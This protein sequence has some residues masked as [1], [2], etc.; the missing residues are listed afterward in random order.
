M[1]ILFKDRLG[2]DGHLLLLVQ[3]IVRL[4]K[5]EHRYFRLE[6]EI[7]IIL[8]SSSLVLEYGRTQARN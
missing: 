7:K 6:I 3:S 8:F 5:F 2:N 1:R 4:G